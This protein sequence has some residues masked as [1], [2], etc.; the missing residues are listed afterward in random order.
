MKSLDEILNE[1]SSKV[2]PNGYKLDE[3]VEC[4]VCEGGGIIPKLYPNGH[5]EEKCEN[6]DGFGLID[7][8][9]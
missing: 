7:K 2:N 6:C 9:E 3:M 5:C 8:E 4:E 1:Y